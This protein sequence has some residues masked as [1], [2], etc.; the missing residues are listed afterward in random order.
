MIEKVVSVRH[1]PVLTPQTE[2]PA[3]E[4]THSW[5]CFFLSF[6]DPEG[7]QFTFWRSETSCFHSK[8]PEIIVFRQ[9]RYAEIINCTSETPDTTWLNQLLCPS[10]AWVS[11]NHLP[12]QHSFSQLFLLSLNTHEVPAIG[13]SCTWWVASLL[14]SPSSQGPC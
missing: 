12:T 6:A 1:R 14:P 7:Q 3:W 13:R 9:I 8:C 4:L 11:S 5:R 10:E 2:A